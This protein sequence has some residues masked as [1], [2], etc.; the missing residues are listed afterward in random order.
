MGAAAGT[1]ALLAA[2]W[3]AVGLL[4][5][6][7]PTEMWGQ[8]HEATTEEDPD[9]LDGVEQSRVV[10]PS[11][12]SYDGLWIFENSGAVPFTVRPGPH[13]ETLFA[14]DSAVVELDQETYE[15]IG[16]REAVTV[17]PGQYFGLEYSIGFGCAPMAEGAGLWIAAVP[18]SVRTL[19]LT[20]TVELRLPA[21]IGVEH[22][23]EHVPPEGCEWGK[24]AS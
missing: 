24:D 8:D 2:A 12:G 7:A 5:R 10:D 13:P 22:S 3:L 17:G 23:T 9:A 6:V 1:V 11:D 21:E 16:S 19:G 15:V 18:V 4:P 20:R 14:R